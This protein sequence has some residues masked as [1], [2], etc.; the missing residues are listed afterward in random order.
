MSPRSTIRHTSSMN[1]LPTVSDRI[2]MASDPASSESGFVAVLR[3][4]GTMEHFDR[5]L[6]GLVETRDLTYFAVVVGI[7]LVL[8]KTSVESVR[9]R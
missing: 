2:A 9:W 7:F 8:T 4:V 1:D 5:L 3:Y 6:T